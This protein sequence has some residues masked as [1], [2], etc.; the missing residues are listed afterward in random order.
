MICRVDMHVH[1]KY[2]DRPS[3]WILRRI[4]APECHTEPKTVY[5]T[6]KRRGMRFVTLTDHN[7]IQGALEIAHLP[8]VFV[9]NEITTYFPEDGCKIHVLVW[10]ISEAQ[11]EEIQRVRA[12]IHELRDYLWDQKIVHSCAHPLYSVNDR[13]TVEHFEKLILLFNVFETVNG[14]RNQR[15]SVSVMAVLQSLTEPQLQELAE[16]HRIE[17]K[18]DHA[19]VKG[20]T[21]G[22]DDHSGVFIAK[23]YTECP[24]ADSYPEFL[25]HLW[26]RRSMSGGL[27]GTPLSLAHSL[28][29][30]G[31]QY[32]RSRFF[33]SSKNDS[34]WTVKVLREVFGKE[35]VGSGLGGKISQYTRKITNRQEKPA[36][37]ELKQLVSKK[38]K[39]IAGEW[40]K[41]D[42]VAD[43]SRHEEL[44]RRTFELA[45]KISNSILFR[46]SKTFIKTLSKGK[47]FGSIEA[48]SALGP[49]ALGVAPYV[50]SFAHQNRD[51]RILLEVGSRF[52]G[53]GLNLP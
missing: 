10:G 11:F 24:D 39:L 25:E 48:L 44:N 49:A 20:F 2:S 3:E 23:G 21:G 18:G 6:A 45:S 36:E 52:F 32:Y 35:H 22:S 19:W 27:H 46:F 17:P 13:L 47:I 53:S 43:S 42:H 38:M 4:G 14:G 29:S 15:S 37:A 28:Y 7:C 26:Q 8:D 34:D 31:Y 51:K 50:F 41:D 9:G 30:I 12:N 33:P 1:S 16:R 40:L 5:E